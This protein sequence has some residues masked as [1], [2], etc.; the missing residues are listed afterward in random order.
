[1]DSMRRWHWLWAAAVTALVLLLGAAGAVIR[2][3]RVAARESQSHVQNSEIVLFRAARFDAAT[4]T[5]VE[6]ISAAATFADVAV[7]Q[8]RLYLSDPSGLSVYDR[9]GSLEK[10]YLTGRDLPPAPLGRM[11]ATPTKLL[12]ATRGEGLLVFDGSGFEQIRPELPAYRQIHDVLPL[13]TGRIMLASGH[14]LLI[15]D[16]RAMKR[17]PGETGSAHITTL[18]GSEGD[19]W[20]GTLA[21]G[22]YHEHGGQIDQLKDELGDPHVLSISLRNDVTLVGTPAGITEFK[23]GRKTRSFGDGYFARAVYAGTHGVSAGTQDEGVIGAAAG[24]LPGAVLRILEL[25][26]QIFA[27]TEQGLHQ[28]SASGVWKSVIRSAAGL[29]TDQNISALAAGANGKLWVGYFDRGLDLVDSTGSTVRHFEDDTLFCINRIVSDGNRT[30]VAT[31]N[32]LVMFDANEKPRQVLTR[33]HGLIADH[34]TDIIFRGE[35]FVAAT[36]AGLTFFDAGGPRSLYALHG[37]VNNHVYALG[38]RKSVV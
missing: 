33:K 20:L 22:L 31:A 8:D 38:D 28:R 19:L 37:L 13:S 18:A 36:P 32:G 23:G 6:S 29:L 24:A 2:S 5:G 7:F 11:S 3:A 35:G 15:Y 16:G 17:G 10:R 27:L 34:V 14:G 30:A 4:N 25:D 26:G 1:M 12:I 9:S 21:D